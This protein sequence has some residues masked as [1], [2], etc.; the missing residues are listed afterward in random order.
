MTGYGHILDM[1]KILSSPLPKAQHVL[2]QSARAPLDCTLLPLVEPFLPLARRQ[3]TRTM[4]S[5]QGASM[6]HD[7]DHDSRAFAR[8]V[9][10]TS[11]P[12]DQARFFLEAA[13]GNADRAI[14]L[15]YGRGV[16]PP[17]FLYCVRV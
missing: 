6:S 7:H 11:A 4:D 12:V 14:S 16:C 3:Q 5:P 1:P 8:F 9:N 2:P 15:Y 13:G 10:L 17:P